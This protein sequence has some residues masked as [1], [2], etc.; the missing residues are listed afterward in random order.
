MKCPSCKLENPPS[1]TR[2]DCGYAFSVPTT[3][4]PGSR[5]DIQQ[6]PSDPTIVSHLRSIDDSVRTIKRIVVFWAVLSLIG[7]L[8]LMFRH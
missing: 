2:C 8:I 6:H 7:L 5:V 4:P 1:A 3:E